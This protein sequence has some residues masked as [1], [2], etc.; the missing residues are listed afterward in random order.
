MFMNNKKDH[1]AFI[2]SAGIKGLCFLLF[3]ICMGINAIQNNTVLPDNSDERP[4]LSYSL[5]LPLH[6]GSLLSDK[7]DY[8]II[9]QAKS[10]KRL[11]NRFSHLCTDDKVFD[12][13]IHFNNVVFQSIQ[14]RTNFAFKCELQV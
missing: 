14:L 4:E 10:N 13:I 9:C 5:N 3:I 11:Q 1:L 12:L 7:V 8:V 6:A 2:L